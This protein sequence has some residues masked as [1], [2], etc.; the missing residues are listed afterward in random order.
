MEAEGREEKKKIKEWS[1]T[2]HLFS[3]VDQTISSGH[4]EYCTPE[5]DTRVARKERER[6]KERG[7]KE[8]GVRRKEGGR[9]RG[10]EKGRERK[11]DEGRDA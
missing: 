4:K 7:E 2:T 11:R 8:R 1:I 3:K 5:W 9:K 6:R 10:R